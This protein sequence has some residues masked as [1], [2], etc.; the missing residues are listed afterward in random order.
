MGG[1]QSQKNHSL[2]IS[3]GVKVTHGGL[4]SNLGFYPFRRYLHIIILWVFVIYLGKFFPYV[5]LP[6]LPWAATI[7]M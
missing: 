3:G 2:Y 6:I 5:Y 4:V 1:I 7:V